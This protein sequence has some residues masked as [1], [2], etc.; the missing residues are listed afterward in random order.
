MK[1]IIFALFTLILLTHNSNATNIKMYANTQDAGVVNQIV[2]ALANQLTQ[3]KN[4]ANIK[5]PT[6][7]I[8]SFV[9]LENF[10]PTSRLSNILSE[11]LIHEMQVRGYKIIDFKTMD[12]IKIDKR[13]D[14]LFSRDISKLRK[15]LNIDYALTGT[16]IKYRSGTVI[17]ARIINLKTHIILSSAQIFIPHRI[18]KNI[19]SIQPHYIP[20]FTPNKITL[21]K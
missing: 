13:G 1:K 3:N 10:K 6:I 14:F 18:M 19:S 20:N 9:S 7:A 4:F 5:Y 15:S 8:T 21:S 17:N 2:Q 16:Y 11:G 12:N